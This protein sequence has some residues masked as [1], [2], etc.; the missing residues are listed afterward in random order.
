MSSP[1]PEPEFWIEDASG[2][3]GDWDTT[4]DGTGTPTREPRPPRSSRWPRWVALAAGFAALAGLIAWQ[5]GTAPAPTTADTSTAQTSA[6][7]DASTESA[8]TTSRRRTPQRGMSSSMAGPST[9]GSATPAVKFPPPTVTTA[10]LVSLPGAPFE[11]VGLAWDGVLSSRPAIVQFQ[12]ETGEITRTEFPAIASNG[13]LSFLVTEDVAVVLPWDNVPGYLVP[14]DQLVQQVTGALARAAAI[15]PAAEA[16][17]IWAATSDAGG[18]GIELLDEM[19]VATGSAITLPEVLTYNNIWGLNSD[20]AGGILSIGVDGTYSVTPDRIQRITHG[21]VL[22]TG[23]TGYLVYECDEA[24]ACSLFIQD[25]DDGT[26]AQVPGEVAGPVYP[27]R[28]RGVMSPDGRY[29]G[30]F[31]PSAMNWPLTV[32]DLTTGAATP[33]YAPVDVN[34]MN[35]TQF[36]NP[37]FAFTADSAHMLVATARLVLMVDCAT[38]D[39]RSLPMI[40]SMSAIALRPAR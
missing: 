15:F 5:G 28:V 24:A 39:S 33:I 2:G 18:M 26:R 7:S 29:A 36:S 22:A 1:P 10:P 21:V 4:G 27:G 16:D 12:S 14:R 11:L 13:P 31:D 6:S 17:R 32:L 23:P 19:G 8:I 38:G 25:R 34:L 30:L 20:G 40:P 35:L 9:R 37:P 3:W